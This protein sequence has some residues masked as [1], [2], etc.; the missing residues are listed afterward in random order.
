MKNSTQRKN[1]LSEKQIQEARKQYATEKSSIKQLATE[2]RTTEYQINKV[3]E[4]VTKWKQTDE[5]R[6]WSKVD[7]GNPDE[8]WEWIAGKTSDGYGTFNYNGKTVNAHK[9]AYEITHGVCVPSRFHVRHLCSNPWCVNPSHLLP[10]TPKENNEDTKISGH[11]YRGGAKPKLNEIDS[12]EAIVLSDIGMNHERIAK[13]K[14]IS[15]STLQRIM[16]KD[17]LVLR[18]DW[19]KKEKEMAMSL[20]KI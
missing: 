4:G 15:G 18:E 20:N 10:G 19:L 11:Q 12:L 8:C 13:F 6:F 7:R 1:K 17:P 14:G 3:L 5:E 16:Q 9:F 2:Y